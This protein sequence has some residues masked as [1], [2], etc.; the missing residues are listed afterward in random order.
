MCS[1]RKVEHRVGAAA[2]IHGT[3]AADYDHKTQMVQIECHYGNRAQKPC[4]AIYGIGSFLAQPSA[5]AVAF[6]WLLRSR[7][8]PAM[9]A[10]GAAVGSEAC[11]DTPSTF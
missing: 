6:S 5:N 7:Q 10:S 2:W 1:R 3:M 8:G 9:V 4:I 11:A